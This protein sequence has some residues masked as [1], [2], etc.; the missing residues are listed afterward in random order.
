MPYIALKFIEAGNMKSVFSTPRSDICELDKQMQMVESLK[1][2][3]YS[4][5][6]RDSIEAL[7]QEIGKLS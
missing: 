4:Q 3:L 5:G 6:I 1:P 2:P 7:R